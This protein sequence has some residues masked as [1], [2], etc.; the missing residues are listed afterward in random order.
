[1]SLLHEV[2]AEVTALPRRRSH[3]WCGLMEQEVEVE[4]EMRRRFGFST[5]VG[6]VSCSAFEPPEAVGCRRRCLDAR[7]RHQWPPT[8]PVASRRPATTA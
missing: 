6:V 1:M 2:P 3:F 4:F 5:P 8:Q 7:F